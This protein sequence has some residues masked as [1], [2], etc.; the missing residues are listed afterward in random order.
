MG[1]TSEAMMPKPGRPSRSP[2]FRS[3]CLPFYPA[4][5]SLEI[6]CPVHHHQFEEFQAAYQFYAVTADGLVPVAEIE[7]R[8]DS[9]GGEAVQLERLGIRGGCRNHRSFNSFFR[10]NLRI[11]C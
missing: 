11:H 6:D 7:Q 4:L 1:G 10:L 2:W 9:V 8:N 3:P 5:S